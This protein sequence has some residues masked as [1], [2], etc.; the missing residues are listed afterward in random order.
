MNAA[1]HGIPDVSTST[2]TEIMTLEIVFIS[3]CIFLVLVSFKIYSCVKNI[4]K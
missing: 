2:G 3:L 1:C 4:R